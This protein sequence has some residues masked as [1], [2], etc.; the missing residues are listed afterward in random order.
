MKSV[1]TLAKQNT[2]ELLAFT[3]GLLVGW[4]TYHYYAR[5]RS[6]STQPEPEL[7]GA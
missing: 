5:V 6:I 1:T 2:T 4:G 3:T 7:A